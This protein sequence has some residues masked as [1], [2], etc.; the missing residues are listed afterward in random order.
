MSASNTPARRETVPAPR[1]RRTPLRAL[2][3]RTTAAD[4]PILER[5]L[6]DCD[7]PRVSAFQSS[8]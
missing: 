8:I 5:V 1:P 6:P 7:V 4:A 2:D 3:A